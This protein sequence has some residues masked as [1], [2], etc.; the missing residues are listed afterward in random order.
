[1]IN[2]YEKGASVR[3][4]DDFNSTH[5][6]CPCPDPLCDRTYVDELLIQGLD[7]LAI[8]FPIITV[9]SGFRCRAHNL[10]VGGKENSQHLVGK[11]ADICSPFAT[12]KELNTAAEVIFKD[13][14]LGRYTNFIHVDT[15]GHRA[16][17]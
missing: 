11:A 10:K 14:G 3:L 16:R 9:N 17:W 8:T 6:D 2:G 5:F 4:S 12:V 7:K 15:R 13:G 1:M